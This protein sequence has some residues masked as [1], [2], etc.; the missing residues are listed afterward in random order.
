[1][2]IFYAHQVLEYFMGCHA[3][4]VLSHSTHF[5]DFKGVLMNNLTPMKKCQGEGGRAR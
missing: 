3:N 5:E 1:M 4:H 2:C